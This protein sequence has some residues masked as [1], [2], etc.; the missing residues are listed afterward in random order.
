MQVLPLLRSLH[1]LERTVTLIEQS[2]KEI[3]GRARSTHIDG[4]YF[5]QGPHAL[6]IT[7]EGDSVLKEI[8][9]NYTGGISAGKTYLIRNGKKHEFSGDY[10][11]WLSLGKSDESFQGSDGSQ[12]FISPTQIDF[13][14]RRCYSTRMVR[15]EY[16]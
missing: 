1:V 16:S 3:G 8:G 4:F 13:T 12:F 11:S 10:G 6:C 14:I 7:A 15:Q 5:K 9:I 2:S